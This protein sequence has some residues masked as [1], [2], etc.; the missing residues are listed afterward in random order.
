MR[1]ERLSWFLV[2]FLLLG[3]GVILPLQAGLVGAAEPSSAAP[4]TVV[5]PSPAA[6]IKEIEAPVGPLAVPQ[7][8]E[9]AQ[10]DGR[11][12]S[13]LANL[14]LAYAL[15]NDPRLPP[16]FRSPVPWD[17]TLPLLR[18]REAVQS[19]PPGPSREQVEAVLAS[20]CDTSTSN[21]PNSTFSTYFY[22]EY[23]TIGGGLNINHYKSSLDA[24]WQQEISTFGWAAPPVKPSN[25]PP[26]NL[27]HVRIDALGSGLYGYVSTSGTHAGPVG[28]NPNTPWN[29]STA[30]AT[31][32]VLNN[33]Y[34][35]FPGTSQQALDATTAHEFHHS[36]QF[37]YGALT[38]S[39]APDDAF[40][41]GSSTWMEDEVFDS[42]NDNY[43]YL[44][45]AFHLCMGEYPNSPYAYWITFRGLTER[46]GSGLAGG[47]EQV[48]QDFWERLS[49]PLGSGGS[50]GALDA[51]NAALTGAGT[52]LADAYH[53]YAIAVRFNKPCTGGYSYPYC[54][55]EGPAYVTYAGTPAQ[56]GSIAAIGGS[57]N[58]GL[59]DNY[60]LNWIRLPSSGGSYQVTL[61]NTSG[62]GQLRLSVVCDTGST[63][64][65]N[66][67]PAV[68][69][70]GGS[71][72]LGYFNPA[73]CV[74]VF[75]V[76]TNQAQTSADPSGCTSRS[77]Q[78]LTAAVPLAT[79][80]PTPTATFTP[81]PYP[82]STLL[83][84]GQQP[85]FLP[86]LPNH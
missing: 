68:V 61:N 51:L 35:P 9:Q 59:R 56:H 50:S 49:K 71:S 60:A 76:I 30:Y 17:G 73:G 47:A 37:G 84:P 4:L 15:S 85:F 62:G 40:V 39:R 6:P 1:S 45:P 36:V 86:F 18:L 38:N 12:D 53:A 57:Y 82:T 63:L 78:L 13:E 28:D 32:M 22:I 67:L 64:L 74:S 8:I 70:P 29:D 58:G 42:A 31:C 24:V 7:L 23:G 2:T 69:G 5:T 19:M 81:T 44:W 72:T 20:T 46:Y 80:T 16:E 26:G 11:L 55:E 3:V 52:N 21:L 10:Q 65:I 66:P 41:E 27:Y 25:P 48:M 14:Y 34:G 79:N 75:A 43:N 77:Y 33:D 54:L 83:A